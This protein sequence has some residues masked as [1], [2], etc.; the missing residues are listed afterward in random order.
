[1]EALLRRSVTW[2]EAS[3]TC[4]IFVP[5]FKRR[6]QMNAQ[7][8][9]PFIYVHSSLCPF[10]CP[11]PHAVVWRDKYLTP[12]RC[13]ASY[14]VGVAFAVLPSA[15]IITIIFIM[16][17]QPPEAQGLLIVE[18]SRSHSDTPHMVGLLWTS[19]QLG[20]EI[21]TWQHTTLA[22]DRQ[23]SMPPVGFE[24]AI[25]PSDRPQTHALD[26]AVAGTAIMRVTHRKFKL[27]SIIFVRRTNA[28]VSCACEVQSLSPSLSATSTTVS[29]PIFR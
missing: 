15:L 7:H 4:Y 21:F 13:N 19:D 5:F 10:A 25:P 18:D 3:Y 29:L 2:E 28:V 11:P 27:I 1:M 16:A 23:T 26:L 24:P 17:Q 9:R 20:T 6:Y 14:I 8:W 22:T 12:T